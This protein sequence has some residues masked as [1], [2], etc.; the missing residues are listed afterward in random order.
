[1]LFGASAGGRLVA[2]HG[3]TADR[4]DLDGGLNAGP[5]AKVQAVISWFGPSDF[6]NRGQPGR[7][8]PAR[9]ANSA[10]EKLFGAPVDQR[11]DL[12]RLASPVT[13]ARHNGPPILFVHCDKDSLVPV[14]QSEALHNALKTAGAD[15]TLAVV[16][17][18]GHGG[19]G[20]LTPEMTQKTVE[21]LERAFR[22]GGR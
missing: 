19:P 17:G 5:S 1:M 18:G 2:L 21:F 4:P 20:F 7:L 16:A 12:A 15:G 13:H 14:Q 10:V 9:T 22:T 11:R 3:L 8:P 6:L